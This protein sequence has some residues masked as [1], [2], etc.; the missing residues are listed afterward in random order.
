MFSSPENTELNPPSTFRSD[1]TPTT[2]G[3][4]IANASRLVSKGLAWSNSEDYHYITTEQTKILNEL[5]EV[6][7]SEVA[8][9]D[10][11]KNI[12]ETNNLLDSIQNLFTIEFSR[13]GRQQDA[14]QVP[15]PRAVWFLYQLLTSYPDFTN[16]GY[17]TEEIVRNIIRLS[18]ERLDNYLRQHLELRKNFNDYITRGGSRRKK[19]KRSRKSKRS[20]RSR[21]R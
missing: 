1:V 5:Y 6:I 21:R 3:S 15:L 20:K 10:N 19:S 18:Q 4:F 7:H 9:Y 11:L 16:N 13:M 8:T 2:F 14:F 12:I 17:D